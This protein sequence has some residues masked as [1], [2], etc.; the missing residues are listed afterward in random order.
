MADHR[1]LISTH[2]EEGG[3][4]DPASAG[5]SVYLFELNRNSGQWEEKRIFRSP[6]KRRRDLFG[7]G[8]FI[9]PNYLLMGSGALDGIK[10]ARAR[11]IGA[12][13]VYDIDD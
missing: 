13:H 4:G 9:G 11:D 3:L 8:L 6:D 2:L 12:I 10:G 7:M 1:A 5:G